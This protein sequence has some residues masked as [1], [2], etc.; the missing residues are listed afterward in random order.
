MQQVGQRLDWDWRGQEALPPQ[1]ALTTT[2]APPAATLTAPAHLSVPADDRR[3]T[4]H[5]KR[6]AAAASAARVAPR[7]AALFFSAVL[8]VASVATAIARQ[9]MP[10]A[11]A[12]PAISLALGDAVQAMGFGLEQV[13]LSGHRFTADSDVYSALK[14]D[15]ERYL[16]GFDGAAARL[17]VEAL[18]WVERAEVTRVWPGQLDV[19][20]SE[21][22]A[23]ALWQRGDREYLIDK[24]G[25][26]LQPVAAGTIT[27]L[28]RVAGETAEKEAANLML[29]LARHTGLS[30]EFRSAERINGRRWSISLK[31]GGRIELPADGEALAIE[32]LA[33]AGE[34]DKLLA[35]PATIVDLRTPGRVAMRPAGAGKGTA[36][37]GGVA[38]IGSLIEAL[39]EEKAQP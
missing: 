32:Q 23:F 17:R 24:T 4:R 30:A 21:R 33:A 26:V 3:R 37:I 15:R 13:A 36:A 14:L 38:G 16:I 22:T 20:V 28:P 7:R 6:K 11:G 29:L 31:N 2:P 12:L 39:D 10:G 25:R 19:R 1:P 5:A 8:A 34:L 27:H 9:G 35:A 18:P